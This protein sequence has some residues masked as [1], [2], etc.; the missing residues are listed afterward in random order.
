MAMNKSY[1]LHKKSYTD[2][3]K[4]DSR[5]YY[6]NNVYRSSIPSLVDEHSLGGTRNYNIFVT[7]TCGGKSICTIVLIVSLYSIYVGNKLWS[8]FTAG[9]F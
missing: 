2:M 6:V 8:F 3:L 7:F 4:T 5:V 1:S 9:W